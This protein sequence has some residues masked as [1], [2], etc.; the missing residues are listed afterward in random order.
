MSVVR[1]T[2]GYR[3]KSRLIIAILQVLD[4]LLYLLPIKKRGMPSDPD[5][6]LLMKPDH[7]GDLLMLSSVLP[8][9]KQRYPAAKLD[10]ACQQVSAEILKDNPHIQKCVT[11]EHPLY[12]RTKQGVVA[13][14]AS[15]FSTVRA[16]KKENYDLCLNMRDA[17]GDLILLA[18]WGGCACI[19]GHA[20]G[21]FGPFL[22]VVAPWREGKHE[23]EHY[24]EVLETIGIN[25]SIT[26][27]GYELY[28]TPE[29]V[30]FVERMIERF[31]KHP[32]V[33]IHPG[34]GDVRKLND[35]IEWIKIVT[36]V[37]ENTCIA[38][39]GT[40]NE[41]K[42]F[43][44]ISRLVTRPLIDLTGELSIHQLALLFGKA[45]HV[46]ALDSLAAHLAAFSGVPATVYWPDFNDLNQWRPLGGFVKIIKTTQEK[47]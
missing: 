9:L 3:F 20:T 40:R 15:L 30:I 5:R 37:P 26:D 11:L 33:I 36:E 39:T 38:I 17:A 13:S 22:D 41:Q 25:A 43:E 46:Y 44:E 8:L 24:L 47:Q 45:A 35:P 12:L 18:R 16:L 19:V 23:V 31:H 2:H 6:I 34:S 10:V 7:F 32:F 14:I 4:A 28:H 42:L 21:G 27:C 1:L 29:D